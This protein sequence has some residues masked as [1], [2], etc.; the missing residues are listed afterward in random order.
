MQEENGFALYVHWPFCR[1]KCPYCDFNSFAVDRIDHGRWRATLL[2]E[3][4]SGAAETPGRTL[5]S[6]F[7]GGGTPSLMQ[8]RTVAALLAEAGR[9]WALADDL[10]VTLEANP[11]SAEAQH[12]AAFA[13]AGVNRLSLGVQSL[14]DDALAFLG[15]SHD[16]AQARQALETAARHFRRLSCDLIYGLPGQSAAAW[17]RQLQDVLPLAGEH[18]S[19]YQ[20]TIEAGTPFHERGVAE[21][22]EKTAAALFDTT[23]EVLDGAGLAAYEVSNH[24]RPGGECRHNLSCWQGGDY[25]GIGP[26]AHGRLTTGRG[27]QAVERIAAPKAWLTAVEA[28]GHGTLFC[29]A[30]S[31]AQRRDELLMT[32]L[33]LGEGV[34]RKR[35]RRRTGI[36]VEGAVDA[37]GLRRLLDGGFLVLDGF[38]L[39][40]TA[41]GL[42]RLDSLLAVLLA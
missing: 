5:T 7:F 22:A 24:A 15:R 8:P 28:D 39:R 32:G 23:R 35:F 42:R 20:L 3:L 12:F 36:D 31:P 30:L 37:Q 38:S 13:G 29:T 34:C 9:H 33:R 27:T 19:P 18:L 14:E 1:S 10:E 21:A 16:A 11:T 26:G 2:G 4:A 17:R 6:V 41:A 25:L 40:A